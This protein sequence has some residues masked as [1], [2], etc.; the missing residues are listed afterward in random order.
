MNLETFRSLLPED[1]AALWEMIKKQRAGGLKS[2]RKDDEKYNRLM[3]D[4]GVNVI[5][6]PGR[7]AGPPGP[8]GGGRENVWPNWRKPIPGNS[9][10]RSWPA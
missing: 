2:A 7:G 4:S 8:G 6:I 3:T 5:Y 9:S 1:Q 10:I